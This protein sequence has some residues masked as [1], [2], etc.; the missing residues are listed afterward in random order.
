MWSAGS[1]YA[2]PLQVAGLSA[3][4]LTLSLAA[5]GL[6]QPLQLASREN[7]LSMP[8]LVLNGEPGFCEAYRAAGMP[9]EMAEVTLP[10]VTNEPVAT[11]D[12]DG[13]LA[14]S[15]I[16]DSTD[17]SGLPDSSANGNSANDSEAAVQSP[18]QNEQA[19]QQSSGGVSGGGSGGGAL[20][21][22]SSVSYTHLTLPTK[23]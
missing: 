6:Q 14:E 22:L 10:S 7:S 3:A 23:A 9:D 13:S 16:T 5:S 19:N 20:L 15:A 17:A 8:L 18:L 11:G 1:R 12:D 2:L 21:W 4:P